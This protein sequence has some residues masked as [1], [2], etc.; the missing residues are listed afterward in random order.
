MPSTEYGDCASKIAAVTPEKKKNHTAFLKSISSPG[1]NNTSRFGQVLA[2]TKV[3]QKAGSTVQS[4]FLN[5]ISQSAHCL[6]TVLR[7]FVI[8]FDAGNEVLP[9][10]YKVLQS[11]L[12]LLMFLIKPRIPHFGHINQ[13]HGLICSKQQKPWTK[14]CLMESVTFCAASNS[15]IYLQSTRLS[16]NSTS[17]RL[18]R[19]LQ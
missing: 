12:L 14:A 5:S 3:A 7:V 6:N 9:A 2:G 17:T 10:G 4:A 1:Q 19:A 15:V 18:T 13:K 16:L 11:R 8:K